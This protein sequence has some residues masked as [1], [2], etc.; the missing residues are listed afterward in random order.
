LTVDQW[1]QLSNLVHCFDE[2]SGL[3]FIQ[4]FIQEQ[5]ALPPKFRFK[6]SSVNAFFTS[7]MAKIQL[8]FE[9]I[10]DFL[11]LSLHDRRT[12]L[13]NT[14]EYT[15]GIG[16]AFILQQTQ[17]FD[18]PAFFKSAELIFRPASVALTKHL[19]D[20]LDSDIVFIKII[21]AI[22]AFSISNYTSYTQTTSDNL[23]DTKAILNIQDMYTELV[24]RYLLYKH[25]HR[26]AVLCFSNLIRCLFLLNDSVVEAHEEQQFTDIIHSVIQSTEQKL[27]LNN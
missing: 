2:H 14:V 12:L 6:H 16:G 13:R 25:N 26:E 5:T 19:I 9:K 15:T 20:Q 10:R 11:S 23:I 24:W 27:N 8:V 17:L 4:D 21:F 18:C 7:M 22:I 1:N 3:S